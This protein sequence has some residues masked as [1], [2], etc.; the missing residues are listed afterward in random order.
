M[1]RCDRIIVHTDRFRDIL[2]RHGVDK[3]RV[4]FI[5]HPF[6]A[7]GLKREEAMEAVRLFRKNHALDGK[8]VLTMFG[9]VYPRKGYELAL[10]ALRD[11]NNCVLLIAGGPHPKDTSGYYERLI[12]HAEQFG[13]RDRVRMIG[14]LSEADMDPLMYSTDIFL[15]PYLDAPG[16]GSLSRMAVYRKPLIA[17]DIA[18]MTE[19]YNRGFGMLLFPAGDAQALTE[20]IRR[21]IADDAERRRIV[22]QTTAFCNK[23]SFDRFAGNLLSLLRM[24]E[25]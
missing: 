3:Q 1:N 8:T 5:P 22:D 19:L 10:T 15:A 14:Y 23:H 17:S 21:V 12:A 18:T 24:G 9:F 13:L 7:P 20:A 11:L 2:L 6:P 4:L 25:G 16:S